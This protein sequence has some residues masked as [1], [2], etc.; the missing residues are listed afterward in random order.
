[1]YWLHEISLN[2]IACPIKGQI[3]KECAAHPS[4]HQTCNTTGLV[5]CPAICIPNG[6]QCPNGTVIDE[7]KNE[8]IAPSECE[9]TYTQHT[10]CLQLV[11]YMDDNINYNISICLCIIRWVQCLVLLIPLSF[12]LPWNT[13]SYACSCI[14]YF[15]ST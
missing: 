1:M 14:V 2:I 11:S 15:K 6:C 5:V 10:K 4:C 7:T 12:I 9:G 8:C 13:L 3:R